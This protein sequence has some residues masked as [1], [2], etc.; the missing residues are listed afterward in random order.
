MDLDQLLDEA[1]PTLGVH[2][3]VPDVEAIIG[4]QPSS[5]HQPALL[6]LGSR[7]A[8]SAWLGIVVVLLAALVV[9]VRV[10]STSKPTAVT[11]ASAPASWKKVTFGGLTMYAPGN[12]PMTS[13]T[14]WADCST[15]S[16]PLFKADSVM[17][18][19]GLRPAAA[20]YCPEI[21]ATSRIPPVY[22]LVIDPG[23]F[24]PLGNAVGIEP[25][26]SGFGKCLQ[27]RN[28]SACPTSTNYGGILVLAVHIPGRTQPVAVEIGLAGGGV[29]AHTILYSMRASGAS[30][31]T[32]PR[33]IPNKTTIDK[34]L[35]R[36]VAAEW[37]YTVVSWNPLT[38]RAGAH[39]KMALNS[40]TYDTAAL[41]IMTMG[42]T[43]GGPPN[44]AVPTTS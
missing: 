7:R 15:A 19:A 36:A 33:G 3:E 9:G 26:V 5:S 20:Y 35:C 30:P 41:C 6:G 34:P 24:G 29:V 38:L 25:A 1:D 13:Q 18:D 43:P 42:I 21:T 8:A 17:L 11:P 37:G 31:V 39:P 14:A 27:I 23:Q 4:R 22:G 16:Q 12:W 40:A 28:L 10:E 32:I 44:T 2:F